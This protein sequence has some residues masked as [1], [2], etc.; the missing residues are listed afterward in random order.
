MPRPPK[1]KAAA[2][3]APVAA[4]PPSIP[5][6]V[7]QSAFNLKAHPVIDV[8]Q[9]I[10]VRDSVSAC[11]MASTTIAPMSCSA[12]H[13]NKPRHRAPSRN[14]PQPL[15]QPLSRRAQRFPRFSQ[16]HPGWASASFAICKQR[17]PRVS[18]PTSHPLITGC[19]HQLQSSARCASRHASWA[20]CT[21][22]DELAAV[23]RSAAVSSKVLILE[24]SHA[25]P[26]PRCACSHLS[27]FFFFF[28][29]GEALLCL[30]FAAHGAALRPAL[31][32]LSQTATAKRQV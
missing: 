29:G 2:E 3:P 14:F 1:N 12:R 23:L 10:R 5:A 19:Q 16:S 20:C 8:G 7:P 4:P 25:L 9:F 28:L 11:E 30:H 26:G 31:P 22:P 6:A 21:H 32:S 13:A 15:P 18:A 24:I 17:A 27:E